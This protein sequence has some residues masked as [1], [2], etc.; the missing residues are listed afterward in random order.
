MAV[1]GDLASILTHFLAGASFST[2]CRGLFREVDFSLAIEI[3]S[4]IEKEKRLG[5]ATRVQDPG[6]RQT[7]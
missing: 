7:G 5:D 1:F 4:E 3:D 6:P 2:S